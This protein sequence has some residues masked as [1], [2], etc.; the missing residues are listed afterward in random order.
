MPTDREAVNQPRTR[1]KTNAARH[2]SRSSTRAVENDNNWW[3]V[4]EN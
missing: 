1:K 4:L 3:R 2:K